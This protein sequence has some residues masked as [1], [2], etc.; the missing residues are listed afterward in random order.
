MNFHSLTIWINEELVN[1]W[2]FDLIFV[3]YSAPLWSSKGKNNVD[4][5]GIYH[6]EPFPF[7]LLW[8][9]FIGDIIKTIYYIVFGLLTLFA[10]AYLSISRHQGCPPPRAN[11]VNS[12]EK[13]GAFVT[14]A[15]DFLKI[16]SVLAEH[17]LFWLSLNFS[18]CGLLFSPL[19]SFM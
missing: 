6:F 19:F 7:Q 4:I 13:L 8:T 12:K 5:V 16:N 18:S 14:S 17:S 11:R 10:L 9:T 2:S 15:I 1:Y 3:D